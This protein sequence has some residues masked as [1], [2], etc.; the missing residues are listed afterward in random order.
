MITLFKTTYK[1]F[2]TTTHDSPLI[3]DCSINTRHNG[4]PHHFNQISKSNEI[5]LLQFHWSRHVSIHSVDYNY[6]RYF[7]LLL[8][9]LLLLFYYCIIIIIIIICI[10]IILLSILLLLLFNIIIII[11]YLHYFLHQ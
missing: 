4:E 1:D 8:L 3:T 9:L 10:V 5:A 6:Y 11:I 7:L 2:N